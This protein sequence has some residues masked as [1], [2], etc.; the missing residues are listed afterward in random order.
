MP[1]EKNPNIE[2][3]AIPAVGDI[4]HLKYLDGLN[5]EFQVR[6]INKNHESYSGEILHIFP[7]APRGE[8]QKI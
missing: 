3:I 7:D 6:I 4:A 1:L 5:Y 2:R 8:R